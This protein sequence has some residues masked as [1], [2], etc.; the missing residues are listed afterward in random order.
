MQE[1]CEA[2]DV[3]DDDMPDADRHMDTHALGRHAVSVQSAEGRPQLPAG[4]G[5][6]QDGG[7]E[8]ELA[9]LADAL[10]LLHESA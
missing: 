8:D 10:L 7:V 4:A 1:A 9:E 5:G 6:L 2:D 3:S